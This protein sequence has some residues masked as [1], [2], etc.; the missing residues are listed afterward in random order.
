[1][2]SRK[3]RAS[4]EKTQSTPM[5][6]FWHLNGNEAS[7]GNTP[8]GLSAPLNTRDLRVHKG[9]CSASAP[10]VAPSVATVLRVCR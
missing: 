5:T 1:M 8:R 6:S 3:Y 2:S 10:D 4:R 9:A 7:E